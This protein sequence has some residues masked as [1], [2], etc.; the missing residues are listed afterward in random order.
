VLPQPGVDTVFTAGPGSNSYLLQMAGGPWTAADASGFVGGSAVMY[1]PGK[2]LKCGSR[3]SEA[4]TAV[5]TTKTIDLA[6][7]SRVWQASGAMTHG[8]VNHNLTVL[9]TGEVIVTGGTAV[10]NNHPI[11]APLARRQPELWS[12]AQ[13]AWYGGGSGFNV[14]ESDPMVRDY[15]AALL[16]LPDGRLLSGGGEFHETQRTQ[17]TVYS[18]PYLFDAAGRVVGSPGCQVSRPTVTGISTTLVTS[19]EVFTISTPTAGAITSVCL[20]RPGAVTHGY[21]QSQRYVPLT[22]ATLADNSGLRVVAPLTGNQAPPGDYLIF[23]VNTDGVPS[24]G[25]WMRLANCNSA[26]CDTDSPPR[27]SDL[28]PDIV[29]PDQVWL[30]WTAPGDYETPAAGVYDLRIASTP[31]ASENAYAVAGLVSGEPPVASAGTPRNHSEFGLTPCTQY[32]FALKTRDGTLASPKNWSALSNPVTVTTIC[33]GGA[34]GGESAREVDGS[35]GGGMLSVSGVRSA[36]GSST[37]SS[38]GI[39]IVAPAG[40]GSLGPSPGVLVA[41]TEPTAAGGWQVTLSL[42]PQVEGVDAA[43]ADAI[44]AQVRDDAGRWRTLG[45]YRPTPGPLGLCALRVRG[46]MVFPTGYSLDRLQPSLRSGG[47]DYALGGA[48]HSRLGTVTQGGIERGEPVEMAAGD[49]LTLRYDPSGSAPA[50][51]AGWYLLVRPNGFAASTATP[52]R[53][54]L[55][56]PL[57]TQ[58]ALHPNQPNPFGRTTTIGFDLPI[59]SPVTIE[60]FDLLGRR[61]ATLAEG[62]YPAGAHTV[63]WD[64]R[65]QGGTSVRPGIYVYRMTAGEFREKRKMSV[66]P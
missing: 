20:I 55:G 43:D 32:S 59:A 22:F 61:V 26:P 44:V 24:I 50:D 3:D 37:V 51:G 10:V 18:P 6:P 36:E 1:L 48:T 56:S 28:S 8:R 14:L 40:A 38:G 54:R 21:D 62:E 27:V 58:F 4:G 19:G 13:N 29:G 60:V 65:A 41:E 45:R 34:G 42:V 17:A 5:T 49:A 66:I 11:I 63:G 33:G 52:A 35:R 39:S 12:P 23:L 47:Q 16:L 7:G 30:A 64:L 9:P 46:R 57:P 15:H 31:I 2:I 53:R 25:R